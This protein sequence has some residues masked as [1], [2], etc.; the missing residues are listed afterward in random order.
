[1]RGEGTCHSSPVDASKTPPR[2]VPPVDIIEKQAMSED[3][4]QRGL[5]IIGSA[6]RSSAYRIIGG[7]ALWT[8]GMSRSTND[9]DI[10]VEEHSKD[11]TKEMLRKN[12][13]FG[14]TSAKSMYVKLNGKKYNVDVTTPSKI[15]LDGFPDGEFSQHM[16]SAMI[17]PLEAMIQ[18][19]VGAYRNSLRQHQKRLKDAGDLEFL[20]N[21]AA[22][23]NMYFG[24][25]GMPGL[26][27][28]LASELR[29]AR[30]E[31]SESLES[32]GLADE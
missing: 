12:D 15:H 6:M 3:Q 11:A 9:F 28:D 16:A 29:S 31:V 23:E 20:L 30:C 18:T 32:L 25:D 19:K 8:M 13:H 21:K 22:T 2:T 10:L 14:Q 4:L 5:D 26:D 17:A 27:K 24:V 7:A 1:M